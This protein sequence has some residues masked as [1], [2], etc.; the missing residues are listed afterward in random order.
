[1]PAG[2]CVRTPAGLLI[3]QAR[4]VVVEDVEHRIVG[5]ALPDVER[6]CQ[7]KA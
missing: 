4:A 7:A 5:Q 1:M 6:T 3:D 2:A